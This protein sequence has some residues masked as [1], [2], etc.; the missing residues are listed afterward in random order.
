MQVIEVFLPLKTGSGTSIEPEIIQAIVEGLADRFGGATAFTRM[1]AD[2]LWKDGDS[3]QTDRIVI[4]EVMVNDVD[5]PWWKVYRRKLE[6]QFEQ[7]EVLIRVSA[8]RTI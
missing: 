8:C 5:E 7:D 1:P 2:G 3:I 6:A 4:V